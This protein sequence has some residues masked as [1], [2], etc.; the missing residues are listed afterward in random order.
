MTEMQPEQTIPG[1]KR[2]SA[3]LEWQRF[4]SETLGPE[5]KMMSEAGAGR[6][7]ELGCGDEIEEPEL[8]S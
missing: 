4:L 7:T 3:R 5:R 1:K 6:I 8:S 2:L